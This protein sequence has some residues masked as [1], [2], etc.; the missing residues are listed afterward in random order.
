MNSSIAMNL[1]ISAKVSLSATFLVAVVGFPIAWALSRPHWKGRRL[2]DILVNLP[3]VLPPTVVGYYLLSLVARDGPIGRMTW[4]LWGST[5][6]FTVAGAVLA[7]MVV[8]LP[9]FVQAARNA[10]EAVPSEVHEAAQ[11]DGATWWQALRHVVLPLAWPG[12]WTGVVVALARSL[13]EF[14]T[15]L[16]VAGNIPGK[17]QTM[18]LAIYSAVQAGDDAK[19]HL[20]ALILTG[21]GGIAMWIGLRWRTWPGR[22]EDGRR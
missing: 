4:A 14:G 16:M 20:L 22:A 17:T 11:I 18:P 6:I 19:A 15:T 21:V 12:I 9:L 8:C 1:W 5:L 13:G 7:S 3:L 10:L 2:V